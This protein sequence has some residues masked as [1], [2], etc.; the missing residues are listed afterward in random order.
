MFIFLTEHATESPLS[1]F[2]CY[3]KEKCGKCGSR[4]FPDSI[5]LDT[6]QQKNHAL[7]STSPQRTMKDT[8]CV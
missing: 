7:N 3:L 5:H 2:C 1:I 4:S 8:H 6:F